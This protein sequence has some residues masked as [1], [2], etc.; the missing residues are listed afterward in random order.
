MPAKRPGKPSGL[1]GIIALQSSIC[2]VDGE[3]GKLYYRGIEL[4]ELATQSTYEE[5][6]YL[7]WN[8]QLPDR[9]ELQALE[10]EMFPDRDLP[11]QVPE[12]IDD[13]MTS[14]DSMEALRTSIS[15]LSGCDHDG[16]NHARDQ[17][18]TR[19]IL[20]TARTPVIVATYHRAR[21]K[22]PPLRPSPDLGT[23]ANFLYML[24]G[25]ASNERHARILDAV[26]IVH[27]DHEL[28][29]STFAARVAASTLAD[30]YAAVTSAI[31]T[32][33]GPLH[34]GANEDVM[35]MLE[36]IGSPDRAE[37]YVMNLLAQGK[38]VPGFGHRVYKTADPRATELRPYAE[39]LAKEAGETR[40]FDISK[41]L[42]EV[43]M[44]EKGLNANLDFI[45]AMVYHGLGIPTDL[46]TPLFACSRMAGWTAHILEQYSDNRL[47]R[48]RAEYVG[49]RKVHYVPIERRQ[50]K[51][52]A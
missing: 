13:Y 30:I 43:M 15:A 46:M 36:E 10:A 12:M 31:G 2:E 50:A 16:L 48:P 39:L 22:L 49:P 8:G 3:R 45:S 17:D 41:K 7:L 20:L 21:K 14:W 23:A 47:I 34:G 42:E 24:R 1:E 29:A 26:L 11:C 33:D 38:K 40:F 28:N 27:A 52:T 6:A 25:E 44:R 5:T 19:A 51:R 18:L 32:L 4:H 37:Q 35:H 9:A